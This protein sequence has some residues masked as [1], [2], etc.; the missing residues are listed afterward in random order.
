MPKKEVVGPVCVSRDSTERAE[1]SASFCDTTTR[2]GGQD[3]EKAR[4]SSMPGC[5][6]SN[7]HK[8]TLSSAGVMVGEVRSK[9]VIASKMRAL[10]SGTL[11][12]WRR[13]GAGVLPSSSTDP[14]VYSV[15]P[16]IKEASPRI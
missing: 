6:S 4:S 14:V 7:R 11:H 15:L 1:E 9:P 8:G 2:P 12:T 13:S 16:D 3:D 10:D 5:S